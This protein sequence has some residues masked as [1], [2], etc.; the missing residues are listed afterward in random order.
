MARWYDPSTGQFVSQDPMVGDSLQSYSY[1][2]DSPVTSDDPTGDLC[3]MAISKDGTGGDPC[4]GGGGGC[5]TLSGLGDCFGGGDRGQGFNGIETVG[6]MALGGF[7][8]LAGKLNGTPQPRPHTVCH[9]VHGQH[10]CA[11]MMPGPCVGDAANLVLLGMFFFGGAEVD[12]AEGVGGAAERVATEDL[13]GASPTEIAQTLGRDGERQAGEYVT[14]PKP[15]V[16]SLAKPGGYRLLVVRPPNS[17]TIR[18]AIMEGQYVA[19]IS[20][21]SHR[22]SGSGDA[23][24]LGQGA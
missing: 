16:A 10:A 17:D 20:S 3:A 5:G 19:Q 24:G 18:G 21:P 12:G 22:A 6:Q 1:A 7:R 13:G 9:E 11:W 4:P 23:R 8:V 14:V 15:R 2:G